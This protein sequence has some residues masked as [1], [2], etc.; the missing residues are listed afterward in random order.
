[1]DTITIYGIPNCDSTKK[2]F[3]WLNDHKISF[4]FHDYKKE[5]ISRSRLVEWC[6]L[7][8]WESILN[9]KSTTW[10]ALTGQE[11]AALINQATAIKI[12]IASNSI[13]KR[14]VIEKGNKLLIGF[15]EEKYYQQ[16]K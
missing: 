2:A 10:R 8:G 4:Y 5:G 1:M 13:I 9:K 16:L 14:P 15:N 12:M 11:Q 3:A 7:A 6:K